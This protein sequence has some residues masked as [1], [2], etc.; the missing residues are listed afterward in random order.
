MTMGLGL[1]LGLSAV[2]ILAGSMMALSWIAAYSWRSFER[3]YLLLV[4]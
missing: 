4:G 2:V 3:L 1:G